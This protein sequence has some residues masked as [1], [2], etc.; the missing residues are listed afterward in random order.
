ML[1]YIPKTERQDEKHATESLEINF[2]HPTAKKAH[3]SR[4]KCYDYHILS[5]LGQILMSENHTVIAFCPALIIS[6]CLCF[7][8]DESIN[9]RSSNQL[10]VSS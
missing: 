8:L 4:A 7:F 9:Q 10:I 5:K 2:F 1:L 6:F 3:K